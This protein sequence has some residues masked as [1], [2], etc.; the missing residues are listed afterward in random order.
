MYVI[1]G[2]YLLVKGRT[3]AVKEQS[4][5]PQVKT[6]VSVNYF[7][8]ELQ[9]NSHCDARNTIDITRLRSIIILAADFPG[10]KRNRNIKIRAQLRILKCIAIVKKASRKV[11]KHVY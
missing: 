8:P 5:Y 9:I 3:S 7:R 1:P 2:T 4:P 6:R 11:L 10:G